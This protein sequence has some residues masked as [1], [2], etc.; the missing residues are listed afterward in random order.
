LVFTRRREDEARLK[1][2]VR[3]RSNSHDSAQTADNLVYISAPSRDADGLG[4]DPVDASETGK[5]PKPD[6][7][8][9]AAREA[10]LAKALR[11]NLRRRKEG[12]VLS[13]PVK[14]PGASEKL[15]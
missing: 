12:D 9:A 15:D 10:R 13:L 2:A 1:N 4:T 14:E 11:A 3:G 6:N 5:P 7:R 8:E